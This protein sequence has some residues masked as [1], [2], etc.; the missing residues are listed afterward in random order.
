MTETG[1]IV[2]G[3]N[4]KNYDCFNFIEYLCKILFNEI[5]INYEEYQINE[6]KP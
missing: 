4:P 6:L 3:N 2:C 5:E 1:D